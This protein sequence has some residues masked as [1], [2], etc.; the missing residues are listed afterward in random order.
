MPWKPR[1]CLKQEMVKMVLLFPWLQKEM[2]ISTQR[3]LSASRI[4]PWLRG[5]HPHCPSYFQSIFYTNFKVRFKFVGFLSAHVE[6]IFPPRNVSSSDL[7]LEQWFSAGSDFI[8]PGTVA[9]SGVIFGCHK[10]EGGTLSSRVCGC[11]DTSYNAQDHPTTKDYAAPNIRSANV[12][13]SYLR[14]ICE[15]PWEQHWHS[16]SVP[17]P[18]LFSSLASGTPHSLG[19]LQ[20]H[21]SIFLSPLTSPTSKRW[22]VPGLAA[23]ASPR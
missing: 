15:L 7:E 10:W 12:E 9:M 17:T 21:W 22:G 6:E 18:W 4:S 23:W 3:H 1:P 5:L 2:L 8:P 20:P 16:W 14:V 11:C 13:K 19:F